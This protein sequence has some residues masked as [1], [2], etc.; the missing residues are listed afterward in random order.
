MNLFIALGFHLPNL[1]WSSN[2]IRCLHVVLVFEILKYFCTIWHALWAIKA[3]SYW[4]HCTAAALDMDRSG[5]CS[6]DQGGRRGHVQHPPTAPGELSPGRPRPRA[7][8]ANNSGVEGLNHAGSTGVQGH[9]SPDKSTACSV[10]PQLEQGARALLT[11]SLMG[12]LVEGA[13]AI[14][15]LKP[16]LRNEDHLA[17]DK[18]TLKNVQKSTP[19]W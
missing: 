8:G 15:Y 13:D 2:G 7:G 9:H 17:S 4:W 5:S 1:K 11:I 12:T 10:L 6:T 3:T 19:K 14:P 18:D 16:W